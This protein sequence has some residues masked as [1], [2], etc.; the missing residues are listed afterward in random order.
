MADKLVLE[1]KGVPPFDGEWPLDF[2]L[3]SL[4]GRELRV[5]KRLSGVRANE[6]DEAIVAGDWDVQIALAIVTLKRA[7]HQYADEAEAPLLDAPV[8]AIRLWSRDE[9]DDEPDPTRSSSRP[10]ENGASEPT[11]DTTVS[12]GARG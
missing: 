2:P 12:G 3:S 1:I 9:D 8:S 4:T 6:L 10:S 5:I 7:G 11:G